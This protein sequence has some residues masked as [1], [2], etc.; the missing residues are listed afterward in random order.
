MSAAENCQSSAAHQTL[1]DVSV[2]KKCLL[3]LARLTDLATTV[4]GKNKPKQQVIL[5]ATTEL[6]TTSSE[7]TM[8][9]VT[10]SLFWQW[11]YFPES[12]AI[13]HRISPLKSILCL[14]S[15]FLRSNCKTE[16]WGFQVWLVV[17]GFTMWLEM[18][19][20]CFEEILPEWQT[21]LRNTLTA[22]QWL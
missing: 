3:R 22:A 11:H 1:N 6:I 17:L 2:S 19:Y 16:P 12:Q 20:W 9:N 18:T 8:W 15:F 4:K 5:W 10:L 21:C 13:I 7:L 14:W